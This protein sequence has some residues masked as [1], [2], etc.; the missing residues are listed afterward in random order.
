MVGRPRRRRPTTSPSSRPSPAAIRSGK[1]GWRRAAERIA[2]DEGLLLDHGRETIGTTPLDGEPDMILR[3]ARRH[4]CAAAA[5][6]GARGRLRRPAA[7][8]R[9]GSRSL[10]APR[11]LLATIVWLWPEPARRRPRTLRHELR[12]SASI[13]ANAA[14]RQQG[15]T[16]RP[17]GGAMISL[18]A[19][20]SGAL[21]L[22]ALQLL[23]HRVAERRRLAA[24]RPPKLDL[25]IPGTVVLM[26]GSVTMWWGEKG[27]RAG[28]Q[29]AAPARPGRLGAARAGLRCARGHR[30]EQ[31]RLHAQD[32]RL[33]L[34]LLHVTGFHLTPRARRRARC[35]SCSSSGPCWA[36]SACAGTRPFDRRDV[37]ALR[38]R[39]LGRR[40][41]T[42]Y[43]SPYL[44]R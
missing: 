28:R 39:R 36:I 3:D 41:P 5:G 19:T 13:A 7:A 10:C 29:R 32:R 1:T 40:V 9:G 8:C 38:H 25:A 30:V 11:S 15:P 12:P 42:F 16:C 44:A 27:I 18:I 17:A 43:I 6:A 14:G 35:W 34:A 4:L 24:R 2:L 37:L 21:R 31:E 20:E 22:S 33:R 26:L 23:L